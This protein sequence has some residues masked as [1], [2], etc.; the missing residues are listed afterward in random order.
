MSEFPTEIP[1][2]PSLRIQDLPESE[3]PREKMLRHGPDSLTDAELLAIFF[4]SGVVGMS[5]VGLGKLFMSRYGNLHALSRLTIGELCD[6]KGIGEAKA[7]HLAAAF[8]LGKRLARQEYDGKPM[9]SADAILSHIGPE[10][11]A[12]PQE[13]LKILL[14]NTRLALIGVEEVTR[15][16]LNETI[17]HPRDILHHV[18][19]RRAH[20]FA[21][22]HN[23]PAGD[24]SPS[25]ADRTFTRR[26]REA[27]EIMQITFVD[28][29]IVGLP[30]SSHA[31][32]FSFRENGML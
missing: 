20:G 8:A 2:S 11:R 14:L 24:P 31:G 7:L 15:G 19:R 9:S 18:I 4:G 21:V 10:L 3:R 25:T 32:Y 6:H 26:L 23:H 22:A 5:A 16:S 1:A 29:L 27:S 13:V 12:E 30:S 17:A 28:H